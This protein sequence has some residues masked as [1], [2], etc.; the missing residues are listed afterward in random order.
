MDGYLIFMIFVVV[1]PNIWVQLYIRNQG[2]TAYLQCRS[3]SM[4]S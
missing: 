3:I 4:L 2:Y 1:F